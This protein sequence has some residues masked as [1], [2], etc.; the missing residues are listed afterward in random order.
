MRGYAEAWA[1]SA[2]QPRTLAAVTR[3]HLASGAVEVLASLRA[4]LAGDR[5]TAPLPPTDPER[6]QTLT[7]LD[8]VQP[9]TEADAGAV[10]ATSGSTGRPRGVVLSRAALIA[11]AE[12]TH[13]RL[14]GPGTWFLALPAQYVAGLMVLVRSLVADRPPVQ[15]DGHLESL[16]S[17]VSDGAEPRY[18][19]VV[20]T[21][22]TRALADPARTAALRGFSAVLLGGAAAEPALLRRA[23]AAGISVVT[24]Y[25]MSETCGGCVYD[26]LPLDGVEVAVGADGRLSIGGPTVFAGYR[27]DP[28]ATADALIGDRLLTRDRGELDGNGR[29]HILG[30]LDDVVISGG[31][32]VDLA[33][34][35][36]AVRSWAGVEA[37][38][39]GVP[40]PEWGTEVVAVVE[41]G[42]LELPGSGSLRALR[43]ALSAELPT[44][45]MPRRLLVG[46][47]LP[48]TAGGKIDRRRLAG[49]LGEHPESQ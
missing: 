14:G 11:S 30:R 27:L 2:T 49:Y 48:R 8:P 39:V 47:A 3:L 23:A 17:L 34:V 44:Y 18:L 35:E 46:S 38:V 12:A 19:S 1:R 10:V 28:A 37:A 9:V 6:E 45:A 22:L 43:T 32:N 5:V 40:H 15:V 42:D 25:G 31:M 13:R 20:P 21:Q 33:V 24:T 7:M 41:S 36:R 26:G 29:L 16:P 4:S